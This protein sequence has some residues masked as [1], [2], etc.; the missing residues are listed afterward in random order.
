MLSKGGVF[1][2]GLRLTINSDAVRAWAKARMNEPC[3][4]LTAIPDPN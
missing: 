3:L 1:V 4:S 2:D